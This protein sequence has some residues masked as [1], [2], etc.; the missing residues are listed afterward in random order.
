MVSKK[1]VTLLLASGSR[2][3]FAFVSMISLNGCSSN[4]RVKK[5]SSGGKKSICKQYNYKRSLVGRLKHFIRA[6]KILT[7]D[8][9]TLSVVEGYQVP[10]ISPPI[11]VRIQFRLIMS[12]SQDKLVDV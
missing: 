10:L 6:W 1:S 9:D 2:P 11:Q 8:S 12:S 5:C 7:S 3:F 4:D